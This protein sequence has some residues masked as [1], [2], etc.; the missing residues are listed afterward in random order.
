M[1]RV[2][3]PSPEDSLRMHLKGKRNHGLSNHDVAELAHRDLAKLHIQQH[4]VYPQD[5]THHV[6][7]PLLRVPAKPRTPVFR[8]T[9]P[10]NDH[11]Y[12]EAGDYS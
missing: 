10:E 4:M 11:G 8:T 1:A 7:S 12:W 2:N 3:P 9:E 5:H 6:D